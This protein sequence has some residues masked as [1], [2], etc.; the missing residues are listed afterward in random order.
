M[1]VISF[2][3]RRSG[4]PTKRKAIRNLILYRKVDVCFL[5]ET[6]VKIMEDFIVNSFW[7]SNEVM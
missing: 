7:G 3:I 6:K 5:Q 4:N 1:N 2:N